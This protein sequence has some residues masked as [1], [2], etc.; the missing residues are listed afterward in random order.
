MGLT[1]RTLC[2]YYLC[3]A[4]LS[5][6]AVFRSSANDTPRALNG[7]LSWEKK[8]FH[9]V[10]GIN[11]VLVPKYRADCGRCDWRSSTVVRGIRQLGRNP[12]EKH[13]EA[14]CSALSP[15]RPPSVF[16]G[17]FQ[18]RWNDMTVQDILLSKGGAVYSIAPS[19]TLDEASKQL[20]KYRVGALMV[21]DSTGPEPQLVGIITERDLLYAQASGKGGFDE[22]RVEDVM[23]K[24][25]I[26]GTPED[27]IDSI[28]ALMTTKRIRH[29][30]IKS[31][32]HLVGVVSIGDV[33]KAQMHRLA[34]ENRFMKDYIRG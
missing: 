10:R 13:S 9:T 11:D 16:R 23:T 12:S 8:S 14:V 28:M 21:V 18:V 26:T 17:F 3:L 30:P 19:A 5:K 34:M 20:V 24:E 22:L 15:L 4:A 27:T 31:E 29:L 2:R 32:G 6:T 7:L 33:V 25:V 1:V